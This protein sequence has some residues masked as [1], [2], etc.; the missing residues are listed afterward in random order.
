[1]Y[2]PSTP[3]R[4]GQVLPSRESLPHGHSGGPDGAAMARDPTPHGGRPPKDARHQASP[5]RGW[6]AWLR[7]LGVGLCRPIA[8]DPHEAA[9]EE[10]KMGAAKHLTL[11]HFEA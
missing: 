6:P 10:I 2:T 11:Q 7:G 5:R 1:M 8:W 4:R 3:R 9:A